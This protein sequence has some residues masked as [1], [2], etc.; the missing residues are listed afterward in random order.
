MQ[1]S[2]ELPHTNVSIARTVF[3][4]IPI[5]LDHPPEATTTG[6]ELLPILV[7]DLSAGPTSSI[8]STLREA[9]VEIR[10][11]DALIQLRA[12]DVLQAVQRVLVGVVLD[13]AEA[14]RRLLEAVEA[15]DEALDLAA[16]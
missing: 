7:S 3:V 2:Q 13:E 14:A 12:A 10:A 16:L 1:K 11:D 8:L 4:R 6:V 15:H 5:F 9:L